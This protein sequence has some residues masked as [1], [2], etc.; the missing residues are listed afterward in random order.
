MLLQCSDMRRLVLLAVCAVVGAASA[1]EPSKTPTSRP[2]KEY[3]YASDGFAIKFPYAVEPHT[4][5]IHSDFKVWTIHLSQRAAISIRLKVDSEPCDAALGKL[6]SMAACQN[7]TIREFSVSG[8][9][10]WEEKEHIRGDN[11]FLERY[12]C[13][14]G[15]YYVLSFAWPASESPQLGMEIMDSFRLVK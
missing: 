1:Q 9:P 6:K 15:R 10:A 11:R 12:V 8:R 2:L 13:G 5:S 3:L 4:D 7:Q 14:V